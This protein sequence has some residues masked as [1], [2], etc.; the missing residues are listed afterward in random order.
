MRLALL[1]IFLSLPLVASPPTNLQV[2]SSSIDSI[3][4]KSISKIYNK[5]IKVES[6]YQPI[7][8]K[9]NAAFLSLDTNL[10]LTD[11]NSYG[12]RI[13]L[14]TVLI[15]YDEATNERVIAMTAH[16]RT[17]ADDNIVEFLVSQTYRDT[18]DL[19][20]VST[21]EDE[22][23]PFT[24]GVTLESSSFWDDVLE[25]AVYVG[26]AAIIIYLLFTVRSG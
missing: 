24:K 16:I 22:T 13:S 10:V 21:L 5:K 18:I 15:S 7:A 9:L 26:S 12:S 4:S 2:I 25:P 8:E 6:K 1:F 11:G 3:A 17:L 19:S 20:S 23:F 14:D